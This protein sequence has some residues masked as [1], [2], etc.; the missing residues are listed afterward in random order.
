MNAQPLHGPQG[1][2]FGASHFEK[3]SSTEPSPQNGMNE[4]VSPSYS[5]R[6]WVLNG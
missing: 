3:A 2:D 6:N 5:R 1:S 4:F